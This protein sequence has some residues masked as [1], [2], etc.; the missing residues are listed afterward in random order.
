MT[1]WDYIRDIFMA[2]WATVCEGLIRKEFEKMLPILRYC[3]LS[4]SAVILIA[5]DT[6]S[7]TTKSEKKTNWLMI[8][9][10]LFIRKYY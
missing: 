5:V 9:S 7:N 4:M 8:Q 1:K 2:P 3:Q 6:L 10:G